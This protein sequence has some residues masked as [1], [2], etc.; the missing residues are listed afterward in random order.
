VRLVLD[1]ILPRYHFRERHRRLVAAPAEQ[2]YDAIWTVT[3]DEMPLVP[4]LLVLR[5]LPAMLVGKA[6]LL[7]KTDE[8]MLPQMLEGRFTL[9]AED[10]GREVVAGIIGQMWKPAGGLARARDGAEFLS[11]S[12]PG[13]VKVAMSLCLEAHERGTWISTETRALAMDAASRRRFALYWLVI[14]GGS[15]AIRRSWLRAI[16][17]RAE[18]SG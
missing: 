4:L 10:P 9:L 13:Y 14:R 6:G 2:L 8:P 16:A 11:F 12:L 7:Q 18:R 17:R 1:E 5:S 15:G 3:M